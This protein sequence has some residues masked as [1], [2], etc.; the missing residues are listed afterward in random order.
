MWHLTGRRR[1]GNLVVKALD[2]GILGT[3][4]G[5]AKYFPYDTGPVSFLMTQF[6]ICRIEKHFP[7]II[8]H[9]YKPINIRVNTIC[10]QGPYNYTEWK[11]KLL[12]QESIPFLQLKATKKKQTPPKTSQNYLSDL[13]TSANKLAVETI[14]ETQSNSSSKSQC[15]ALSLFPVFSL[16][17]KLQLFCILQSYIT[18]TNVKLAHPFL[19]TR[20]LFLF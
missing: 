16:S 4:F 15:G 9:I 14:H 2:S 8:Q 11:I 17:L 12:Q 19:K 7:S 5:S 20:Q 6:A 1:K 18:A 3:V 10:E 13:I